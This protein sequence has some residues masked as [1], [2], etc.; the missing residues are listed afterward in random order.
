[1]EYYNKYNAGRLHTHEIPIEWYRENPAK[2]AISY[3]QAVGY[4]ISEQKCPVDGGEIAIR[5]FEPAQQFDGNNNPK[6]R[7]AYINFHEGGWVFGNL[8]RSH[9]FCKTDWKEP[10]GFRR[11]LPAGTWK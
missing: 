1:M 4:R 11:R 8:S 9:D 2:Y 10:C 3:G 7:A 6:K 5:I